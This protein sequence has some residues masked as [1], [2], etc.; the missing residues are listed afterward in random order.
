[1][2]IFLDTAD[3]NEIKKFSA[4]GVVDGVTT[5]PSIIAKQAL[6][7][8]ET[9][10]AICDVVDGPVS[11]EVAASDYDNMLREGEKILKIADNVVLKLPVTWDGVKACKHFTS[12]GRQTNL[13]LC[14][15]LA[16]SLLAAKAG[17]TYISPFIGRLDDVGQNGLALVQQIVTSYKNYP[18]IKTE[19]LAASVRNKEHFEAVAEIGADVATITPQL[20]DD[21]IKHNLTDKGIE[22]F[23]ND[24]KKAGLV[25]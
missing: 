10:K 9:I 15:T 13:T 5:N 19:V 7:F 14:F 16:Q 20:L 24:W 18:E 21:L 12:L 4:I 11:A 2:K 17:A 23:T 3:I 8:K 1:M 6:D 22:I 25:I